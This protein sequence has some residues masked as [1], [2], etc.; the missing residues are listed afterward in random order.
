MLSHIN[1]PEIVALS[2]HFKSTL[3]SL[4]LN[5]NY[6]AVKPPKLWL[7]SSAWPH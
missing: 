5:V 1:R 4:L 7:D 6:E 3:S 2:Q